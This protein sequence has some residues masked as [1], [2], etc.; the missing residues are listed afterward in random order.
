MYFGTADIDH[1]D[2]LTYRHAADAFRRKD[3]EA[4]TQIIHEDVTW[5]IP[6]NSRMF[7]EVQG[8]DDLLAYLKEIITRTIFHSGRP[9]HFGHGPSPCGYTA[10]WRYAQRLNE[11][12]RSRIGNEVRGGEAADRALISYA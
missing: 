5:H 11:E 6:G 7:Q 8:R 3:L 1:P 2:A 10:F 12:I 9:F 4:L